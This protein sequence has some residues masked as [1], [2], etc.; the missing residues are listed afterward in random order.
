MHC[1]E[2]ILYIITI[3]LIYPELKADVI[4]QI[5]ASFY[6]ELPSQSSLFDRAYNVNSCNE[7]GP[8][9]SGGLMRGLS[10]LL[11]LVHRAATE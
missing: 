10:P 11:V 5:C 1:G 4:I 3:L 9:R 8:N 6:S 7:S 2:I